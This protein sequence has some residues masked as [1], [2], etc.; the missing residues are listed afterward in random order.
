MFKHIL[1]PV[2]SDQIDKC[3]EPLDV[4]RRMLADGGEVSILSVLEELPSYVGS[5]F[6]KDQIE[7]SL[8]DFS[9][10]LRAALPATDNKSYVVSG[11]PTNSIL[12]W[13]EQNQVDCIVIPSHRPG[14]SDYLLGSTAARVTRHAQCSVFVLRASD[15]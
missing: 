9:E 8:A 11:H 5:Y 10:I 12:S 14:M 4:A 15:T 13:A 2:A 1:V 3:S 7:K 6:S